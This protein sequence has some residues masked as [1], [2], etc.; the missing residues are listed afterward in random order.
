MVNSRL[1]RTKH[2]AAHLGIAGGAV[3]E[4]GLPTCSVGDAL[5]WHSRSRCPRP[6]DPSVRFRSG[7]VLFPCSG[8]RRRCL[9]AGRVVSVARAFGWLLVEAG[10]GA[11]K[12]GTKLHESVQAVLVP[13][14]V[15]K[16][17]VARFPSHGVVVVYFHGPRSGARRRSIAFPA[18]AIFSLRLFAC[19][20]SSFLGLADGRPN[21][22]VAPGGH[23]GY[24]W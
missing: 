22:V 10:G 21:A 20:A 16:R 15:D 14:R 7:T 5:R 3:E 12:L 8:R 24:L 6:R 19:V 4:G 13:H 9:A 2:G 17:C 1:V 23:H 11:Q 18:V